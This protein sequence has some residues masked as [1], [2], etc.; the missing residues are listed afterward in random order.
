MSKLTPSQTE[1]LKFFVNGGTVE[2]CTSIG[3]HLG[4]TAFP[5]GKPTKFN[6]LV[7]N[8]LLKYGLLKPSHEE[9]VYGL[10]WSKVEATKRGLEL[11][12]NMESSNEAF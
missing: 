10:R 9:Y 3:S 2:L 4:K 1:M 12:A 8:S 5:K 11:V 7:M 6:K